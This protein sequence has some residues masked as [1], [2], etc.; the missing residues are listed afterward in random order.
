MA[1]PFSEA[2]GGPVPKVEIE[3]NLTGGGGLPSSTDRRDIYIMAERVT[4]GT[5]VAD[6]VK[7]TPFA[8]ANDAQ[9][10]FGVLSPGSF[11]SHSVFNYLGSNGK[12]KCDVYGI[13]LAEV[14][15]G[16]AEAFTLTLATNSTAAG[17]W[18]FEVWGKQFQISVASGDTP[19]VQ[20]LAVQNAFNALTGANR[21][22]FTAVAA[23][24]VVTFTCSVKGVAFNSTMYRTVTDPDIGTTDVWASSAA[25]S[26]AQATNMTT[27]LA[28]MAGVALRQL[29]PSFNDDASLE[30]LID[31]VNTNSNA[32]NMLGSK[33][34]T[35]DVD[36][37]SNLATW[38]AALDSD[39]A[40]RVVAVGINGTYSH[41]SEIAA[42]YAALRASETHLARSLNG[43]TMPA[44]VAPA[45]SD[46]FTETEQSTLLEAGVTP[47]AVPAG[48]STVRVVRE[49]IVLTLYGVVD[50]AVMDVY[51]YTRDYWASVISAN[52]SRASIVSDTA[53]LP[54]VPHITR[55]KA[56]KSLLRGATD[57]LEQI[58]Y[59]T[60]VETNWESVV[61][62][63]TA[64]T[65]KLSIPCEM[66]PQLHNV[67]ISEQA[68]V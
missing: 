10:W 37:A 51:D 18:V 54:P 53:V 34:V 3:I 4:A 16:T 67:M 21:P 40:E 29:V 57:Q 43:I 66:V 68:A 14:S 30:E 27:V 38:A 8:D 6:E 35:A 63:T 42:R 2:T 55:P 41:P 26:G 59:L 64:N 12:S 50:G 65:I 48:T 15:G 62:E 19:T 36:T 32:T 20:A 60:N 44:I 49:V 7:S 13:A 47:L 25:G 28:N 58:G 17:T 56:V 22:P 5:S 11:M 61:V 46:V 24:G 23:V 45:R 33:L 9:N 52:L 31:Q 39:D 1:I